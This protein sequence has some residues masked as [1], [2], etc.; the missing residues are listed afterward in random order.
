MPLAVYVASSMP[1]CLAMAVLYNALC[2]G[3]CRRF[4]LDPRAIV[5]QLRLMLVRS[6]DAHAIV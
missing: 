5:G 4:A 3:C 2:W 6:C 1:A